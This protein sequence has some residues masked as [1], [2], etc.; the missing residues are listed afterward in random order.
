MTEQS[1]FKFPGFTSLISRGNNTYESEIG[2]IIENGTEFVLEMLRKKDLDQP[3][4]FLLARV[5]NKTKTFCHWEFR[6]TNF[7][8]IA[9]LARVGEENVIA[10]VG[11][12]HVGQVKEIIPISSFLMNPKKMTSYARILLKQGAAEFLGRT[13]QLSEVEYKIA[14]LKQQ[15]VH[16]EKEKKRKEEEAARAHR[17]MECVTRIMNRGRVEAFAFDGIPRTGYPVVGEEWKSLPN[18]TFAILVREY[19]DDRRKAGDAFEWFKVAKRGNRCEKVVCT[20]VSWKMEATQPIKPK[21]PRS[22]GELVMVIADEPEAVSVYASFEDIKA[23]H[24]GGLN[25]ST[26][27]TAKDRESGGR[28]D[29]FCIT[30]E[31]ISSIGKLAPL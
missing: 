16:E 10:L 8:G 22:T 29:V 26:Y 13:C 20:P 17:Q 12:G 9:L 7:N 30:T 11:H 5:L 18:G 2:A 4:S 1:R 15:A 6:K 21:V 23:A 25:G 19:D 27:V 14:G 28:Y 24:A 31:S 3:A